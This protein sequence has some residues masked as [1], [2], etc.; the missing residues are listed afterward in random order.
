M[1]TIFGIIDKTGGGFD[2][3]WL[4]MMK[5][6]LS[7]GTPDR[8]GL[9]QTNGVGLGNLQVFNTP[10][11]LAELL[12]LENLE[13]G[14]AICSD[15]RIDN[16]DQLAG[17]LSI[18]RDELKTMP[19]SA[20]MLKAYDKLGGACCNYLRGD[21]AFGIYDVR[22]QQF[23]LAR[24]HF[25]MRPLFYF[26]HPR[27]FIFST[28]LRGILALPIFEKELNTAWLFDFLIN[29]E[30]EAFDTFY[31]GIFSLPPGHTI[32]VSQK[33]IL[34]QKYW[35]L[36]LPDKM[37][38][39]NDDDL[40]A[41]YRFLFEKAVKDRTRSAFPV[42]AELSGGLD[43]SSIVS[44]A[45]QH[46]SS[47]QNNLH[48]FARILPEP[49]IMGYINREDDETAQIN[50]VCDFC[51]ISDRHFV[52]MGKQKIC[53]NIR[54][55]IEVLQTPFASNYP[56]YNLN[57]HDHAISAG[58]R[59]M[60]SGHGGDQMVTNPAAFVYHDYLKNSR[61]LKLFHEIRA[62]GTRQELS[63]LQT[64]RYLINMRSTHQWKEEKRVEIRKMKKLGIHPDFS[65]HHDLE[66]LFRKHRS[67]AMFAPADLKELLLKI[68]NRHLN[69]RVETTAL[70]AGHA[71]IEYRYPMF[72]IDLIEFY[73]AAPDD[74][75]RKFRIG[76][77]LHRISMQDMLPVSIQYRQDKHVSINP[78]LVLLFSNDAEQIRKILADLTG[79]KGNYLARIFNPAMIQNLLQDHDKNMFAY[80]SLINKFFQLQK[81]E[82]IIAKKFG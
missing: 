43:S 77:Y 39:K 6:D 52:T 58:V 3:Q 70:M 74:L 31:L 82:K 33:T 37:E 12:P 44:F 54:Q 56:V 29:G 48:V 19:D 7:H 68:T 40:I 81:F 17:R 59:T 10:E 76:R 78:G 71:S 4:E 14:N 11:S 2:R 55:T 50:T 63:L 80:K 13:T 16:R 9:W 65:D 24:D 49:S 38:R 25:G 46:L 72:D 61:Y 20:L 53:D 45:Q 64:I 60:L 32:T 1:S 67:G 66:N 69:Y 62:S 26:D 34:L 28:E 27:Y 42:G 23:V 41:E 57:V 21:F 36:S 22:N 8:S 73:L 5:A 18:G 79:D 15:S 35:E 75:K 30:R 51:G 47:V